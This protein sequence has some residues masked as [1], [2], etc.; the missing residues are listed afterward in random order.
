MKK[1]IAVAHFLIIP[2]FLIAQKMEWNVPKN[3]NSYQQQS[4]HQKR[5]AFLMLGGGAGAMIIGALMFEDNFTVLTDGND[6]AVTGGV[7]L[8]IAGGLCMAGSIPVF[9]SSAKNKQKMVEMNTGLK[10]EKISNHIN[11]RSANWVY[12][13]LSLRLQIHSK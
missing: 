5:T 3:I 8:M 9:I 13:A 12:P 10:M 4:I 1:M 7:V 11:T 6:D 2:F